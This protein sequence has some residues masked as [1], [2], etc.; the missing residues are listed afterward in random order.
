MKNSTCKDSTNNQSIGKLS[1]LKSADSPLLK[2]HS[3]HLGLIE[4]KKIG[5]IGPSITR[6]SIDL[7]IF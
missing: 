1:L 2:N 4:P 5:E 7:N 6:A 3:N